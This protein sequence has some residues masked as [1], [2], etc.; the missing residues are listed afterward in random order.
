MKHLLLFL[1]I[2]VFAFAQN[3][4]LPEHPR[5]DWER[6]QWQ[7]LNGEWHFRF[8]ADDQGIQAQ[9]FKAASDA[10]PLRI[11]VPFPWGSELSGVESQ[12]DL[13]W[14][15]HNIQVP[16][17]WSGQRVFLVVGAA[18]W[19]TTAWLDGVEIGKH[20]GG[21]TPFSFELTA[22]LQPGQNQNLVLRIDDRPHDFKLEGKQ[23]YGQAKGIWQTVYLETRGRQ[24]LDYVHFTPDIDA[25][26]VRVEA[27][28]AQA[29]T[30]NTKLQLT[31]ETP[32]QPLMITRD[33]PAGQQKLAF[34]IPMPNARLWSLEDPYL[35]E[36]N[37]KLSG[38]TG[39]ADEVHTYFGMRKVSVVNLPGT[40]HRYVALNN[41]P[42]Y[43]QL[44]LDQSYHPEGF[45]TFPTD[46]FMRDE[47]LRTRQ[48]G[49][50][51]QR[52]HIKVEVPRK[53]YWAD[54]LGV[55]IMADV[56]NSW[57]EPGPDMR[58][59]SEYAMRQMIQRDYNHPAIFSWIVFNETWGLTSKVMEDGKEH[60]RYLPET[61]QWVVSMV[62]TAKSLDASRLVEDN[63]ICCGYGHTET[64]IQSW[65]AY[66][67]GWEW[68]QMLQDQTKGTFAGSTW[69]YEKGYQQRNEPNINSEFG[70]V[71]GYEGSTG[72]V[73]WSWDYHRSME[74]F[75]R[76]PAIAGW[77]YTEHHDVINEW[78]GYWRFDRTE[79]ETG[80]GHLV[81]GMSLN[82]LHSPY[83]LSL[84]T[85]LCRT[86]LGGSTVEV[87]VTASFMTD[88]ADWGNEL[89]VRA[90]LYG[91]NDLGQKQDYGRAE[92]TFAAEPWMQAPIDTLK[93]RLPEERAVAVLAVYLEDMSGRVLH[94]N[95]TTFEVTAPIR[96]R[97]VL[98]SGKPARVTRV[99]A[100]MPAASQWSVKQWQVLDGKKMN[101]AGSGYFEYLIPWP[102]G[103]SAEQLESAT[104]LVEASSKQLFGKDRDNAGQMEG[105]YMRGKGTFDPSR[106]PNAYPMTD[107]TKYPGSVQVLANGHSAGRFD[108]PD[109]PADHRGILSW[110]HQLKDKKLREAGSYGYL[111][112]ASIP[113]AALA[114][115]MKTKLL[116]IRLA[117]DDALASGL[118]IYG[119]QFGRYPVDP[120]VVWVM[121]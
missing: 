39:K 31:I 63:S 89:R 75:R 82:D 25:G 53:L 103:M 84:G 17:D 106:N 111:I 12:A 113:R 50:N 98:P 20:R 9:W 94:H 16:A 76:Y 107:E 52:I 86:V 4:P 99:D 110:H 105:D 1:L 64:D 24:Y 69:N 109:D 108:L 85:E 67:P 91:W 56:P 6:S 38:S 62:R 48:I 102:E 114:E 21:Y 29:V 2:P 72:D 46:A 71:W 70:N 61:Q 27:Q 81:P 87:P 78:N 58:K 79:K 80:L 51:G 116:R 33:W 104:F 59:E 95:F 112:S 68:E 92:Y 119:S 97:T 40:S 10:F 8:D 55:L 88:Q 36:V 15:Q 23:G 22:H 5:P 93:I 66:L 18:D 13:A 101:G 28:A 90:E 73:D 7:N 54:K 100:G 47:I 41:N 65:H 115:A 19:E 35:Y 30:A 120:T 11:T 118:A 44:T 3:I 37:A 32:N 26:K 117:V 96:E 14:Y 121:K 83:Y 57:G 77:L 43:L 60:R 49:L 45:Y 42:V 34:D 74:A